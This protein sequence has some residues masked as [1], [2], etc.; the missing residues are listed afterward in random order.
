MRQHLDLVSINV[1][2]FGFRARELAC[3][4]CLNYIAFNRFIWIIITNLAAYCFVSGNQLTVLVNVMSQ[5]LDLVSVNISDLRFR[6]RELATWLCLNYIT[7][8]RFIW[9]VIAY[10]AS[11]S[12]IFGNRLAVLVNIVGQHFNLIGVNI[13]DFGFSTREFTSWFCLNYIAGNRFIWV[14]ITNLAS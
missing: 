7:G 11:Q 1:G 2:D 9:I 13:S 10:L 5:H 12:F 14:I 4:F 3:R 6:A 8:N